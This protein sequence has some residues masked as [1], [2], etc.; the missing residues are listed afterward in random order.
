MVSYSS[1]IAELIGIL[2]FSHR[3]ELRKNDSSNSWPPS[4]FHRGQIVVFGNASLCH[5]SLVCKIRD[6]A[7]V[8]FRHGQAGWSRTVVP[9]QLDL[10]EVAPQQF[11]NVNWDVSVARSELLPTLGDGV[12][13]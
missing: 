1:N 12:N 3:R 8:G 11:L 7:G 13:R 10:T 4:N 5:S 2:R 9:F 6:Y